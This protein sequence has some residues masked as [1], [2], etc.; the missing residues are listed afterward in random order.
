MICFSKLQ[1][2][3]ESSFSF[4]KFDNQMDKVEDNEQSQSDEQQQQGNGEN[5]ESKNIEP[6]LHSEVSE[7]NKMKLTNPI[8]TGLKPDKSKIT[9]C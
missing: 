6:E 8:P 3:F 2:L 5:K 9:V 4:K 7:L 1:A